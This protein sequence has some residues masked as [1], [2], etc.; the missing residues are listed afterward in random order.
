M[1]KRFFYGTYKIKTRLYSQLDV[2][3]DYFIMNDTLEAAINS[4]KGRL[5]SSDNSEAS[6]RY[7]QNNK[8]QNI[9]FSEVSK[10]TTVELPIYYYDGL[11]TAKVNS[12]YID[13]SVSENN[14]LQIEIDGNCEEGSINVSIDAGQFIISDCI[15]LAFIAVICAFYYKE[16]KKRI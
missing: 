6:F 11:Y 3:Y 8:V 10:N 12:E 16:K 9:Y 7:S 2:N 13:I 1:W 15:S 5:F 4:I 14:L